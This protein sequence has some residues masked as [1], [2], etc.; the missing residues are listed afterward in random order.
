MRH[1]SGALDIVA[2]ASGHLVEED[3]FG[4]AAS[5]QDG[6]A[7][8]QILF[9]VRQLVV[10]RQLHGQAQRHAARN[11]G[12]FMQRVGMLNQSG[13]QSVASFVK[14]R[15]PLFLVAD[16]HALALNAH[17]HF[18]FGEFEIV[19]GDDFA[20][21]AGRHQRRFIHQV[22]QIGAGETRRSASDNRKI[23]VVTERSFLG[24]NLENAF[25]A[26]HIG[27]VHHHPAVKTAGPQTEPDQAHPDGLWPLPE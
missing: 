23:H 6:Q 21:L 12:D 20:I 26:A 5:H 27:T 7:C 19:L 2:R 3:F 8:F 18:V 25:T 13:D 17:Q 4:D 10:E 22:G 15:H 1:F 11:D 14:S 16:D 9:I 24:M